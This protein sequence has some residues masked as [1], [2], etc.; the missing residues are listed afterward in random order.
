MLRSWDMEA[1]LLLTSP[2]RKATKRL[3][4]TMPLRAFSSSMFSRWTS[5]DF[6][7]ILVVCGDA[8]ACFHPVPVDYTWKRPSGY[9]ESWVPLQN[10]FYG[11]LFQ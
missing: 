3:L 7:N 1:Q 10:S 11:F 9:D 2:D 6:E 4:K 8:L 5:T